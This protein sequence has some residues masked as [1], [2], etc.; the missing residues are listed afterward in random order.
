MCQKVI[1]IVVLCLMTGTLGKP[2]PSSESLQPSD[3]PVL[4]NPAYDPTMY[5]KFLPQDAVQSYVQSYTGHNYPKSQ[6]FSPQFDTSPFNAL[7]ANAF[8][9]YLIPVEKPPASSP[10]LFASVRSVMPSARSLVNFL[11]E[12]VSFVLGSLGTVALGTLL[13]AGL[14][15]FTP[16]CTLTFRNGKL[17]G[18][19]ETTQEVF[20]A[21]GD[22]VTADRVKRAA[23]FVKVAIDKFQQLNQVVKDAGERNAIH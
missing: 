9:T 16:F 1:L 19:A 6:G 21:L 10:S 11:A 20:N 3:R 12:L 22:Q 15:F 4:E 8:D 17:L 14:C 23:E 7:P 13:T 5:H 18:V 2:Q